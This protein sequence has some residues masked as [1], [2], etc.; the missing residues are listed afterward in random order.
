MADKSLFRYIAEHVQDNV[1]PADLS[2]PSEEG[3]ETLHFA[4]GALE[5]DIKSV[6]P[7]D[8]AR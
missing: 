2:L 1:L 3:A 4:D 5:A 8:D 7:E 6:V